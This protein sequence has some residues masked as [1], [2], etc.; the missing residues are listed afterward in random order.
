MPENLQDTSE[1]PVP[2]GEGMQAILEELK[3]ALFKELPKK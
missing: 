2:D 3:A 1:L